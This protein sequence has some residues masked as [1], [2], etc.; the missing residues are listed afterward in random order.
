MNR[1][2]IWLDMHEDNNYYMKMAAWQELQDAV[3][4][5]RKSA[6][7]LEYL[8]SSLMYLLHYSKKYRIRLPEE[9]KITDILQKVSTIANKPPMAEPGTSDDLNS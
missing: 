7:L 2:R 4:I 6:E 5:S 1:L 3:K 9:E 8:T